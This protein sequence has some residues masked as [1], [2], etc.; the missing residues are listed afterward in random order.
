MDIPVIEDAYMPF[1][2]LS[3]G[4]R[5]S[6]IYVLT[7]QVAGMP[8]VYGEYQDFRLGVPTDV[9]GNPQE[10]YGGRPTDD[11]R[12]YVW[13]ER[14]NTCF[15]V[16]VALKPRLVV[17]LPFLQGRVSNVCATPLNPPLS[18][19]PPDGSPYYPD[20]G[21]YEAWYDVGECVYPNESDSTGIGGGTQGSGFA[22]S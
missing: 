20:G 4:R 14:R 5:I 19:Y 3:N 6:D 12:F 13:Q 17:A 2:T 18:A 11:G 22:S 9:A 21:A 8:I 7:M 16:R 1:T 10:L 15:D